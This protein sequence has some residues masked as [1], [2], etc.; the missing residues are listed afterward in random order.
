L[1]ARQQ[2]QGGATARTEIAAGDTV[3]TASGIIGRVLSV[4]GDRAS[5][6]I[7]PDTV[8]EFHR[9][10]LGRRLDP[11]PPDEQDRWASLTNEGDDHGAQNSTDPA[12]QTDASDGGAA[13]PADPAAGDD[14]PGGAE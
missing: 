1:L 2:Q 8:V 9:S 11:E 7:A 14:K 12:D 4:D 13:G 5:V 10:T 6:E 3:V